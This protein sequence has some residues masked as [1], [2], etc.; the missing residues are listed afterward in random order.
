MQANCALL[1]VVVAVACVYANCVREWCKSKCHAQLLRFLPTH[2]AYGLGIQ[3][4]SPGDLHD[5][6]IALLSASA[7]SFARNSL[8]FSLLVNPRPIHFGTFHFRYCSCC[9]RLFRFRN[10][11]MSHIICAMCACSCAIGR[12]HKFSSLS[13]K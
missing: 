11:N 7:T 12:G 2:L 5:Y 4:M 6:P 8:E 1:C 13:L 3:P 9:R 10:A